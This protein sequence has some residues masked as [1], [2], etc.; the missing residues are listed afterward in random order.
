MVEETR[1]ELE[2]VPIGMAPLGCLIVRDRQDV[3]ADGSPSPLPMTRFATPG[4][5]SR[6]G[7][8]IAAGWVTARGSLGFAIVK[9]QSQVAKPTDVD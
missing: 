4:R 9:T 7:R 8:Y 3:V 5:M 2:W 1:N 6:V